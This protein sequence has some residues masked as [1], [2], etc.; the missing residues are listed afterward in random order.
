MCF[1]DSPEYGYIVYMCALVFALLY[2]VYVYTH[3]HRHIWAHM[4]M[5][6][7]YFSYKK[8]VLSLNWA[9]ISELTN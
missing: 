4:H 2:S 7:V 3:I 9:V 8:C 5:Y 6:F 1:L